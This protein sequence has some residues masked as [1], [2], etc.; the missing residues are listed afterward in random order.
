VKALPI[1]LPPW[2]LPIAAI[3]HRARAPGTLAAKFLDVVRE[4]ASTLKP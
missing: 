3:T 4:L 2:D 1:E